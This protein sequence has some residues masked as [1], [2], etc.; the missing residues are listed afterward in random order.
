MAGVSEK[1]DGV[2]RQGVRDAP[3]VGLI[4]IGSYRPF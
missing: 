4:D 3:L 1:L 2:R